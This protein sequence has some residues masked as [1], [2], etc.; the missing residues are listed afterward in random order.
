MLRPTESSI[1][2][3]QQFGRGLRKYEDKR[4]TVID[5]IG[6]HRSFLIKVRSLLSL[7]RSGGDLALRN[8]L[9]AAQNRSLILP[10]GCEVTYDLQ[11]IDILNALLRVPSGRSEALRAYYLDFKDRYGQRPTAGEAF[12]DGYD[13]RTAR[14]GHD[15]SWLGLVRTEGDL[16]PDEH[17]AFDAC[18][19]FLNGLETTHLPRSDTMLVL[20]AMLNTD[21]LPSPEG[22]G[23]DALQEEWGRL[24]GRSEVLRADVGPALDHPAALRQW[25]CAEPIRA[26]TGEGAIPGIVAFT[27]EAERLRF[28]LPVPAGAR[29]AFQQL[30]RE[31]V[32]WRLSEY[33]ATTKAE[34]AAGRFLLKAGHAHGAPVLLLPD[35]AT[36]P[37][38][39]EGWSEVRIEGV[40][41]HAHFEHDAITAVR[42]P[43]AEGNGLPRVLR[44]W[45][46]HDAGH[47]GTHHQVEYHQTAD[48][49]ALAP[50]GI[51]HHEAPERLRLYTR[52]QI[53]RLFGQ[54]FS[55]AR[56]N[57][58]FVVITPEAPK[59]LCLLVTLEKDGME[60]HFHYQNRFLPDGRFQW[61]SQ[62]QTR[63]AGKHG[64]LIHDHEA[65]GIAVHLFVRARKR[66][67]GAAAPFIYC[68]PVRFESWHGEK[69]ITVNWTLDH[70]LPDR[71][72]ADFSAPIV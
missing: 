61:Q 29:E 67:G 43:G 71:L 5:Y 50:L 46:G 32:E 2:W 48:G 1:I 42:T 39:P 6:N 23:L 10:P 35:R 12:H 44:G 4:L 62:N 7:D 66:D 8:A 28:R 19:T 68:G 56:W 31:L 3:L 37:G 49:W 58:G 33:L 72:R 45:F 20:L 41:H 21:T 51:R 65:S 17:T 9:L 70:P 13:P 40:P 52:E 63:Q 25:L 60:E 16:T 54:S 36:T 24:A 47:P 55:Q 38:L 34:P 18:R 59:H 57:A 11:V 22:I 15:G 14:N 69:P 26:W 64:R 30:V 27:W 53:P